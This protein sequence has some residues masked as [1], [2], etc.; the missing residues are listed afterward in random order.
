[1]LLEEEQGEATSRGVV[2]GESDRAKQMG[3]LESAGFKR[4]ISHP[5]L[6]IQ[7]RPGTSAEGSKH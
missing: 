1:M 6:L 7:S 4:A 3:F 5:A 2:P